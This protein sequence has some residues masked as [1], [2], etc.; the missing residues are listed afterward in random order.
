[1]HVKNIPSVRSEP[2]SKRAR[3]RTRLVLT[4]IDGREVRVEDCARRHGRFMNVDTRSATHRVFAA[5]DGKRYRVK[6]D[7]PAQASLDA[8]WLAKQFARAELEDSAA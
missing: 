8:A 3:I 5:P 4:L 2:A 7:T 1:M 6:L